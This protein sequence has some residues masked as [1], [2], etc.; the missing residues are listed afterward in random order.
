MFILITTG[1]IINSFCRNPFG[2]HT[3]EGLFQ[4]ELTGTLLTQQ[5]SWE[6]C[7]TRKNKES[8]DLCVWLFALLN[9]FLIN[10]D[11]GELNKVLKPSCT[12]QNYCQISMIRNC[13]YCISVGSASSAC[14][15]KIIPFANALDQV[16]K[17]HW[18]WHGPATWQIMNVKSA[19]V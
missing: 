12:L 14:S 18:V 15:E 3:L 9:F 1:F 11:C 6:Q 2:K 10:K 17:S 19:F 8:L 16:Q 13:V 4:C 5:I 7:T